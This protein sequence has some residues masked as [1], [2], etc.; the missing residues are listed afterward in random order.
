M[1]GVVL[2]G[3][4]GGG[5]TACGL[6]LAY[7]HADAF[8][9]LVWFKALDE[10]EEITDALTRFALALERSLPEL[11]MVHLLDD[12]EALAA[13][14]PVLTELL[15]RNRILVVL[16]NAESLLTSGGQWRDDRWGQ[17]VAALTGHQGLGRVVITTRRVPAGLDPRMIVIAIDALSLDESVT[18]AREFPNLRAMLHADVG[19]APDMAIGPGQVDTDRERVRRTLRVVQGHPKLMEFADAAAADRGRLD[20][21]LTA[22]EAAAAGQRLEAFF[23]EGSSALEAEQFLYAL[24]G[25]T[26]TTLAG[27]AASVRLMAEFLACLEDGDRQSTVID[28]NWADLWR[29]LEGAG[30]PPEPRPQ[31]ARL[32]SAALVQAEVLSDVSD[33]RTSLE[34]YRMHPAMV[35][36]VISSSR[37]QIRAAVDAELG[38]FWQGLAYQAASLQSGEDTG[39][40]VRA[41]LAAV[42][43]L[44][45]RAD[46]DAVGGLLESV[47][48]RDQSPGVAHMAL[49]ALRR[50]AEATGTTRD[51]AVLGRV[52]A[53]VDRA[54]AERLQR[55]VLG[56]SL[57]SGD[58]Q[59]AASVA[60]A[61]AWLLVGSGRLH[62]ALEIAASMRDFAERAGL[63]PWTVAACQATRLQVLSMMGEH[64]RLLAEGGALRDRLDALSPGRHVGEAVR[65][66][67]VYE[68]VLDTM[69]NS[70]AA[71]EDWA[72]ALDLNVGILARKQS[73]GV[74]RHE[75]VITRFN[76]VIPLIRL[77]RLAEAG[78]LLSECQ[79]VL[80]DEADSPM[81]AR[82]LSARASLEAELRHY[83]PAIDFE[84][85]ALRLLYSRPDP[86]TI[87][88]SHHN[89]ASYLFASGAADRGI[90]CH[91]LAAAL[92]YRLTDNTH[93][94][95]RTLREAARTLR[96]PSNPGDDLT[97]AVVTGDVEQTEGVRLAALIRDL[98]PDPEATESAFTSLLAAAWEPGQIEAIADE[99]RSVPTQPVFF[100]DTV[101]AAVRGDSLAR[102]SLD[103]ALPALFAAPETAALARWVARI[104]AGA[105]PAEEELVDVGEPPIDDSVNLMNYI[106]TE[107][108]R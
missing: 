8:Q 62:E 28:A 96:A 75:F 13:F 93:E 99:E 26:E 30:D 39:M 83:Q 76:D 94:L 101:V 98:N 64:E 53:T 32:V 58:Y 38:A 50:V 20:A 102:S 66:W 7:T 84:S 55:D 46:W 29:R 19:T 63:G 3:M 54:E 74:G 4:P 11:R 103:L 91:Q 92:I 35:A 2:H 68:A 89:L 16:D 33:Q 25:W 70:A 18:L 34:A 65:S 95:A 14:L 80:E 5:K 36:A 9:A 69:R 22:A 52:L 104:L 41:G 10:G 78:R 97:L 6:E 23:G 37:E 15:E 85:T 17:V 44:L 72:A 105:D 81:L 106:V 59:V 87:A 51:L 27:L 61:L 88:V 40:V 31:L 56:R 57:A 108:S 86:A 12:A 73:R 49:S 90:L 71:L 47:V 79:A 60:S 100:A 43:Y 42:P 48:D 24:V 82:L 107:L 45:R 21:Q 1:S 67:N 77:D